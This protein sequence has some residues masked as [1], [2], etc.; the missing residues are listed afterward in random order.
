MI[1]SYARAG[2]SFG[3]TLAQ[4]SGISLGEGLTLFAGVSFLA[5]GILWA[6]AAP[7]AFL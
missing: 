2:S 1:E 4:G 6:S 5:M 3:G 7:K